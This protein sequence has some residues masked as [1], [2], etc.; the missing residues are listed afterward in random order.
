MDQFIHWYMDY[1]ITIC[2]NFITFHKKMFGPDNSSSISFEKV[3]E[4]SKFR[5]NFETLTKNKIDK[6]K[7]LKSSS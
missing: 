3:K 2:M 4:L 6:D 5:E 1:L 7:I